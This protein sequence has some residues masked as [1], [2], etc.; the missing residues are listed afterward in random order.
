MN[1]LYIHITIGTS[2]HDDGKCVVQTREAVENMR[3]APPCD[4]VYATNP[5]TVDEVTTYSIDY[6][7]MRPG[8]N[9]DHATKIIL[10]GK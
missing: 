5:R 4:R 1:T 6:P 7:W 8:S 3:W 10:P 9:E 2:V